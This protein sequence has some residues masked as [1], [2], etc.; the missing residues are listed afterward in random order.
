MFSMRTFGRKAAASGLC[1]ASA[2]VSYAPTDYP[3]TEPN[4]TK[5]SATVITGLAPGDT[6]NGS[7]DSAAAPDY[8]RIRV[9]PG[10]AGLY[11]NRL[12]L[13]SGGST[14]AI[15]IRGLAQTNGV[16]SATEVQVQASFGA[17]L[18][19]FMVQWYGFGNAEELYILVTGN[20]PAFPAY[21]ATFLSEPVTAIDAGDFMEGSI[22]FSSAGQGH[23]TDTDLWVYDAGFLPIAGYGND[24]AFGQPHAQSRLSRFFAPGVYYIAISE[25]NLANHLASPA[26]DDFRSGAVMDFPNAV[27]NSGTATDRI[28][29]FA[30]TDSRG[31]T[32]VACAK[33]EPYEVVWVKLRVASAP[34]GPCC[35]P[36][37]TCREDLTDIQCL[38]AGGAPGRLG[39]LCQDINCTGRCCLP[40]TRSCSQLSASQCAAQNGL[41]G[42]IGVDCLE[43]S[44]A[45]EFVRTLVPPLPLEWNGGV[46]VEDV[47]EVPDYFYVV[48]LDVSLLMAYTWQ[49]DIDAAVISPAGTIV[50]IISRPGVPQQ[51][52]GFS[53]DDFGEVGLGTDF[54]L[55]DEAPIGLRYD[56]GAVEPPGLTSVNGLWKP[57]GGSLSAFDGEFA[58]GLWRLRIVVNAAGD[59]G[60]LHRW[61]LH[62]RRG[63]APCEDPC[64]G[65]P[66]DMNCDGVVNILDINPFVL[67][68]AD[69]G[70]Y[71]STYPN[72]CLF[73]ADI[74]GD[75]DLD[76]LDINPFVSLLTGP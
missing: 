45:Q 67:A 31:V 52:F 3:E 75:F 76:V 21:I 43:E 16:I 49:G 8:F 2:A 55:D 46:A 38:N 9:S 1:L 69:A 54:T 32:K 26:D 33:E 7:S 23:A 50:P 72:C 41:F 11:R 73:L 70:A 65:R 14:H 74:N 27:A 56:R 34:F 60:A 39:A 44:G 12:V 4:D 47:M 24:D 28:L 10:A 71:F 19:P 22:E 37:G 51:A 40:A 42:G 35:L 13:T 58:Q 62:L 66:G 61:K 6:I 59:F 29:T 64:N 48:D 68:L 18:P 30:I 20:S 5:L 25:R 53:A 15:S 17:S 57:D 36:D 63:D